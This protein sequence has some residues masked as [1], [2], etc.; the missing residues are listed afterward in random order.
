[1]E[2]KLLLFGFDTLPEIMAIHAAAAP[3]GA[4]VV[5]VGKEGWN[6]TLGELAGLD[7]PTGSTA[8]AA[9]GPAGKMMVFCGLEQELDGL[10]AALRPVGGGALKAVLTEHNRHWKAAGLYSELSRERQAMAALR[11]KEGGR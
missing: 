1:M 10:L 8:P 11:K 9:M 2:K 7:K 6:R 4:E 3:F 5:S